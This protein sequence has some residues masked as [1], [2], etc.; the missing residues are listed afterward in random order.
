MLLTPM[1]GQ[2]VGEIKENTMAVLDTE[3][4]YFEDNLEDLT[5][6]HDGK[7]V[8]I[9]DSDLVGSFDTFD[10]AATEAV[11]LYGRGPYLIR[12]VGGPEFTLPASVMY[13]PVHAS[14]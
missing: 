2:C 13:R 7:W 8:I 9:H 14:A 12:Q 10:G 4:K 11:R 1:G 6:H 3:I 5:K